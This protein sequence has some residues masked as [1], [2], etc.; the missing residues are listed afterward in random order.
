MKIRILQLM[1]NFYKVDMEQIDE[2]FRAEEEQRT[3]ALGSYCVFGHFDAMEIG[4]VIEVEDGRIWE[5]LVRSK[6]NL[7][8]GMDSLDGRCIEQNLVCILRKEDERVSEKISVDE[9]FWQ[10]AVKQ[11]FLFV[12]SIHI[13]QNIESSQLD[14]VLDILGKNVHFY[15]SYG[16]NEI[17]SVISCSLYKEGISIVKKLQKVLTVEKMHTFFAVREQ[18]LIDSGGDE[19]V[20]CRWQGILKP[21]SDMTVFAQLLAE[22]LHRTKNSPLIWYD[23]LGNNDILFEANGVALKDLLPL[24]CM[25]SLLTHSNEQYINTW[26]NT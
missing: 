9:S 12:S 1:N 20:D 18:R 8:K 13:G 2:E 14:S 26:T 24:Y 10:S 17:I 5:P 16:H 25:G 3:K 11:P 15:L 19:L 7:K 21:E 4:P 22:K 6:F 23:Q